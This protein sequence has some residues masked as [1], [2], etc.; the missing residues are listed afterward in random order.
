MAGEKISAAE[1]GCYCTG[2]SLC[3]VCAFSLA[4]VITKLTDVFQQNICAG[5][6]GSA[7]G[8]K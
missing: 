2:I 7:R 6:I 3:Y 1:T 8:L 4:E 5:D